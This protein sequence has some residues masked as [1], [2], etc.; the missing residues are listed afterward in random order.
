[1]AQL[2]YIKLQAPAIERKDD[3]RGLIVQL[4]EEP[5]QGQAV[6]VL[7][8]NAQQ[9]AERAAEHGPLGGTLLFKVPGNA[10]AGR[11]FFD[12]IV[13]AYHNFP[14]NLHAMLHG[15]WEEP[16]AKASAVPVPGRDDE[17]ESDFVRLA[18]EY[19]AVLNDGGGDAA[20]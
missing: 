11:A 19:L 14:R 4:P 15:W 1:M 9:T 2:N 10:D 13:D 6:H 18:T 20:A 3:I 16:L 12:D 8:E 7:L 5:D 17:P